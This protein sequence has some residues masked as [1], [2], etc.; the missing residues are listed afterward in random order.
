MVSGAFA[1]GSQDFIH[2]HRAMTQKKAWKAYCDEKVMTSNA[3][4][5]TGKCPN[6]SNTPDREEKIA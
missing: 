6:P 1:T 3:V 5:T 4:V 2:A